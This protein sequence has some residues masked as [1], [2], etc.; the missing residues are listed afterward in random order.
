MTELWRITLGSQKMPQSHC[1]SVTFIIISMQ[2][3]KDIYIF[4]KT[5]S[6]IYKMK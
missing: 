1:Y 4:F 2:N 5:I 6:L 3:D